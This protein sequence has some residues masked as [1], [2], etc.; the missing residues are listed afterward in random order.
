MKGGPLIAALLG[1]AGLVPLVAAC[2]LALSG[3]PAWAG[4]GLLALA[5][6]AAV[7]L[8]FAG[9]VHW[10]LGLAAA[11]EQTISARRA[12]FGMGVLPALI[13]WCGM[14]VALRQFPLLGRAVLAVGFGMVVV[15]EARGARLG[16]VPRGYMLL[17]SALSLVAIVC[18]VSVIIVVLLGGRVLL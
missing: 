14:R 12:R 2:L 13:G 6:Y 15:F 10:G 11:A 9:G 1:L 18:L 8:A 17:R 4:F 3:D 16:L 7:S 5:S